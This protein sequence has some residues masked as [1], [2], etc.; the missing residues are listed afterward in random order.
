MN[1]ITDHTPTRVGEQ[2]PLEAHGSPITAATARVRLRIVEIEA[3]LDLYEGP[4]QLPK[5]PDEPARPEPPPPAP[6]PA[7]EI[8]QA[9]P[10]DTTAWVKSPLLEILEATTCRYRAKWN[11]RAHNCYG[12][13]PRPYDYEADKDGWIS[14]YFIAGG[15]RGCGQGLQGRVSWNLRTNA[16]RVEGPSGEDAVRLA[17]F[18]KSNIFPGIDLSKA[19]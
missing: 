3:Q 1:S 6:A 13:W 17:R 15:G 2:A 8:C 10:L 11:V 19:S 18:A 14:D 9:E 4:S 5:A 16:F 7:P 12:E